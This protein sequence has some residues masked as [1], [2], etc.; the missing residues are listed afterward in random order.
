MPDSMDKCLGIRK[1]I[2]KIS[3]GSSIWPLCIL[4]AVAQVVINHAIVIKVLG[5]HYLAFTNCIRYMRK[6]MQFQNGV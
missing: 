6:A 2:A 5:H 4:R 1:P 3:T